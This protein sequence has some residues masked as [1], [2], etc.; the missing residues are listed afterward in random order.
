M[1][2]WVM[3]QPAVGFRYTHVGFQTSVPP[4]RETLQTHDGGVEKGIGCL[5]WL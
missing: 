5:S 3:V 4:D 1:V 2:S